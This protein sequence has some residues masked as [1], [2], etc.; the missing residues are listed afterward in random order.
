VNSFKDNMKS[1]VM[2]ER[3]RKATLVAVALENGSGVP[4]DKNDDC[5]GRDWKA[6]TTKKLPLASKEAF[7]QMDVFAC[8]CQHCIVKFLIEFVQLAEM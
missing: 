7:E 4:E 5:C 3:A 1:H 2:A 6:A 8:M